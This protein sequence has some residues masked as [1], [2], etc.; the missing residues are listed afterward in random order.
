ME[1]HSENSEKNNVFP[2]STICCFSFHF[3]G[4]V[5]P[6]LLFSHNIFLI[7]PKTLRKVFLSAVKLRR[8]HISHL[9]CFIYRYI[10]VFFTVGD[11]LLSNVLSADQCRVVSNSKVRLR[12]CPGYIIRTLSALWV[13]VLSTTNKCWC[14]SIFQMVH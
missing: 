12:C 11:W 9:F 10:K 6:F 13:S 1:N 5:S 7:L 2:L 4:M 3:L 14:M 8:I